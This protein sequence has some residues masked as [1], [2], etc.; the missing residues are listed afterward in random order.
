VKSLP[1]FRIN[2]WR[3][4]SIL[5]LILMEVCWVTPWFRSLT[6]ATNAIS[7]LRVFIVVL[8]TVLFAHILVRIMDYLQLKKNIHRGMMIFFILMAVFIGLKTMLYAGQSTSLAQLFNQP[9][10]SFGDFRS[11]IPAEFIVILTMLIAFWRGISIAQ[12]HIGPSTIVDHF[13]LGIVMYVAFIFINTLATGETPGDFFYLF[14]FG[15]LIAMVTSRMSVIGMLR[16]GN[17]NKFN[18]YWLIGMILATSLTVALS[19]LLGGV[20]G[21]HLDWIGGLFLGIFGGTMILLWLLIGPIV[22]LIITVL[23]NLINSEGLQKLTQGFQNLNQTILGFGQNILDMINQSALSRFIERWGPTLRTIIFIAII[24]ILIAGI[25]AWTAIKLWQDRTR[26]QWGGEQKSI[27]Q[28]ENLLQRLIELL[29][30]GLGNALGTLSQLADFNHRQRLRAAARIRQVY[31]DLMDL[32]AT[33]GHP[34]DEADTPLEFLP[35]IN[36]LFPQQLPEATLITQA[37]NYIRYGQLPETRQEVE[38]VEAAWKKINAVGRELSGKLK[39][40]KKK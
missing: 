6:A 1:A 4:I 16:G 13:W 17:E 29:R 36:Q 34:R 8:C 11:L 23:G 2:P 9:L 31:A 5:M 35:Q 14:L 10:T 20:I 27:L 32:C 12:E 37:Y 38:E 19:A 18:R 26:R 40:T 30:G 28:A 39:Q 21:N 3:E 15:T 7:S 22:S 33:L 25:V 24:T